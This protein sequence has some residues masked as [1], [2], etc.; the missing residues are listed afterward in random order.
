MDN[1]LISDTYARARRPCAH[2]APVGFKLSSR[3]NYNNA[4]AITGKTNVVAHNNAAAAAAKS[5]FAFYNV[6]TYYVC[7][8]RLHTA[9]CGPFSGIASGRPFSKFR[10]GTEHR[11]TRFT[12]AVASRRRQG[13]HAG[14]SRI[15]PTPNDN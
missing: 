5:P 15:R 14:N 1:A 9:A 11:R 12:R 13:R 3:I 4:N 7:F 10:P 2:S 8:R 6:H